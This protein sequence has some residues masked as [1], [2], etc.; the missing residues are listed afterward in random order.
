[1]PRKQEIL[2]DIIPAN[3][4]LSILITGKPEHF[5]VHV[6]IGKLFQN[7]A[8]SAVE[9]IF[10]SYLFLAV[11]VPEMLFTKDVEESIIKDINQI[12]D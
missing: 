4:A 7:L 8:V 9:T 10:L 1:M 12:V 5:T 6:G 3:R 11:D 2:R